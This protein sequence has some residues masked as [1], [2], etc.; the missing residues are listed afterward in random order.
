MCAWKLGLKVKDNARIVAKNEANRTETNNDNERIQRWRW[1]LEQDVPIIGSWMHRRITS[2]LTELAA[3]G[4]WLAAQSLARVYIFHQDA[5]V[6]RQAE[7]TLRQVNYAT[8]IDAVWGVW[9]ETRHPGLEQ[10]AVDYQRPANHPASIRL[11]SLL[12]LSLDDPDRLSSITRGS[13]DLIPALI[14]AGQ[15]LDPRLSGQANRAIRSLRNP[16]S[17]DAVCQAWVSSRTPALARVISES[18]YVAQKPAAARVLTALKT[19]QRNALW[20][21]TPEMIPALVEAC[22]DADPEIAQRA[23][24]CLPQL[25]KQAAVDAFCQLWS[26]S[27][28]PLLEAALLQAGYKAHQPPEVR[29]LAALK[30][31]QLLVAEKATPLGLPAL[32]A[33]AQDADP[34]IQENAALALAHLKNKATLDALCSRVIESGDPQAKAIALENDYAPSVPEVRA[35]FYFLTEQWEAYDALDFDQSMLRAI[36]AASPADLRQRIAGRVQ[37]AGRTDYL[38]ILAGVDYRARSEEVNASEAAL[39]IRVL[40][41]NHEYQRL[42]TLVPELALPFSLEILRILDEQHWQP[43]GE[44]EQQVFSELA[45]LSRQPIQL[46]NAELERQLPLAIPRATLKVKGRINEVAFS[47]VRPV[48]AIATSQRKVVL[49]NY[50]T[51]STERIISD[52]KH[53]VGKVSYL[54]DGTLLC[55][56]RTSVQAPCTVRV[57]GESEYELCAHTGTV[58][59][60]EPLGEDWVLTAGR[61]SQAFVWDLERRKRIAQKEYP[62]WARAAAISPDLQS[63]ALLHDRLTLVRLPDLTVIP[64]YPY[65]VPRADGFKT[66]VAQEAAFSPDGKFLLAGQYNGQVGMYFHTSLT[67]RPRRAVLT[68]HPEPVRG[69]TFLPEHPL[70]ITAGAEGQVRFIRWPELSMPGMVFSP[71]GQLTSLRV[72]QRGSFMATGTN[73]AS[74]VLWDLR[75]L[76]IPNM[77]TRPLAS[78]THDQ[79]SDILALSAYHSLPEPIR[80][81]LLFL[82]LLL[83]YRFR[84]DIQ[85]EESPSIRFGEFDILLDEAA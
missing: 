48:L 18:G 39:L 41:E 34:V 6:R 17:V 24:E 82:K 35:L 64:G 37:A 29:L 76:D 42:W 30:T 10:I 71:D 63:A 20:N 77:F 28:D 59:V 25:Q 16:A 46:L 21:A 23:L 80:N 11:L 56:E 78:A 5:D 66:G 8:G 70:V 22:Q 26:D 73:E 4:N 67:Q 36:Y 19:D 61:D 81:G 54:P 52:F 38:T 69:V 14:Q 68:K 31:G 72:S 65:I 27:R 51:G 55:G 7:K 45:V 12:R 53:S 47:P 40:A 83:Q 60:L 1:M 49:W 15:D 84:Y 9:A 2:A 75:T 62:F 57:I 85:I 58:T 13:A 32:L 50:R 43:A 74:L 44:L 3:A 33:A 79:V